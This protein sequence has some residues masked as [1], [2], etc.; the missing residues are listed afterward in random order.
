[1]RN[2][3]QDSDMKKINLFAD[4]Y[5]RYYFYYVFWNSSELTK[6]IEN[7][8]RITDLQ[9]IQKRLSDDKEKLEKAKEEAT[10]PELKLL[11]SDVESYIKTTSPVGF[12][13]LSWQNLEKK[14]STY[15][16]SEMWIYKGDF[17][18]GKAGYFLANDGTLKY[19]SNGQEVSLVGNINN[20]NMD[21]LASEFPFLRKGSNHLNLSY[22]NSVKLTP[23]RFKKLVEATQKSHNSLGKSEPHFHKPMPSLLLSTFDE[24]KKH[25]KIAPKVKKG[26]YHDR[27]A[28]AAKVIDNMNSKIDAMLN[29]LK[30]N[31]YKKRAILNAIKEYLKDGNK[32]RLNNILLAHDRT[33]V[34]RLFGLS[35]EVH[36]MVE[37]IRQLNRGGLSEAIKSIKDTKTEMENEKRAKERATLQAAKDRTLLDTAQQRIATAESKAAAA[38]SKATAAESRVAELEKE[39]EKPTP[40]VSFDITRQHSK[41]NQKNEEIDKHWELAQVSKDAFKETLNDVLNDLKSFNKELE[42]PKFSLKISNDTLDVTEDVSLDDDSSNT[43]DADES[44]DDNESTSSEKNT[45]YPM[46]TAIEHIEDVVNVHLANLKTSQQEDFKAEC[47]RLDKQIRTIFREAVHH[48]EGYGE[49][50]EETTIMTYFKMGQ[51]LV[52]NKL[53]SIEKTIVKEHQI[54]VDPQ[55]IMA[56]IRQRISDYKSIKTKLSHFHDE[57]IDI[58]ETTFAKDIKNFMEKELKNEIVKWENLLLQ[59]EETQPSNNRLNKL[60]PITAKEK[61]TWKIMNE[62]PKAGDAE[63]SAFYDDMTATLIRDSKNEPRSA[64]IPRNVEAFESIKGEIE[65]FLKTNADIQKPLNIKEESINA[66]TSASVST[67]SLG[68]FG[69]KDG[70]SKT[71]QAAQTPP[72]PGPGGSSSS[73]N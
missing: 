1:M 16:Q 13:A 27:E 32:T 41:I 73:S 59:M 47:V 64:K 22:F 9:D 24:L 71:A 7:A 72:A 44:L 53:H 56:Q 50:P 49:V 58:H 14:F 55:D 45:R 31:T 62:L 8:G 28:F 36:R 66:P 52:E 34:E 65:K 30:G 42:L 39:K 37:T 29:N 12:D 21:K 33:I 67:A 20:T 11:L 40:D 18:K 25:A 35:N 19:S 23:E 63:A 4:S 3:V 51:Q 17:Q 6:D 48:P 5:L 69:A 38:E 54:I 46:K 57:L 15:L 70:G 61:A 2:K 10:D 68:I 26:T 43:T 60:K